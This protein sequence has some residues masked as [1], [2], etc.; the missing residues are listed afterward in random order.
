MHTRRQSLRMALEPILDLLDEGLHLYRRAF[1][2]ILILASLAGLPSGALFAALVIASDWLSTPPGVALLLLVALLG[3]PLALYV[4]GAVSRAAVMAAGGE[5]VTLRRALALGPL[6]VLGMGCYGTVF[7]LVAASVVSVISS[8]CVCVVYVFGIAGVAVFASAG[9][10][11]GTAGEVASVAGIIALIVGFILMYAATLALN[12]AAYSSVIFALQPFVHEPLP[13]GQAVKRSLDL[14]FYRL[15]QNIL[16]FLC[17]SIVFGAIALAATLAIGVLAPLPILFLLGVESL[18]ARAITAAV[19][20]GAVNVA[21]PLLPIWMALLYRRRLAVWQG[22][23]LRA[24]LAALP[25]SGAP[26]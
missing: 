13:M 4:V 15:G 10:I 26:I 24:R 20:I 1:L 16:A 5:A 12:G 25:D 3:L 18:A 21:L 19:W 9:A 11:G 2:R 23:D 7:L 6:R 17:A 14:T 8:V 22:A